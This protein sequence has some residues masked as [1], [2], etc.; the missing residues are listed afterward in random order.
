MT[1]STPPPV[2]ASVLHEGRRVPIGPAGLTIG[3]DE[4]ND[5]VLAVGRV[6]RHHARI[7]ADAGELWVEDLGSTNGTLL[8]GERFSDTARR[9]ENGDSVTI[10]ET[11]LRLL[12]GEE[13]RMASREQPV[14]ATRSVALTE[15]RLR[16]GRDDSNDLVLADP[17]VS[18]FHAEI[19]RSD[20]GVEL[21]D[22][23]SRNGTRVDGEAHDRAVLRPG[24]TIGIGPF[25]LV[26]DGSGLETR[27]D[28]GALRLEAR[29][30][31][32][33]AGGKRILQSTSLTLEPG[34]LTAVIGASG[35]GKSTLVKVL[36]GVSPPSEGTVTANGEPIESR[37]TDVAYVPQDEIV[38]G[39]LTVDEALGY[40][41]RLRLPGD[42]TAAEIA[43]AVATVEEEL[44]LEEQGGTRIASLSGG[45]RKRAGVA[46]ELISRAS[47]LFLDEPASGLDPGLES[48]MM[49]LL[50]ELADNSRSVTVVTHAT[51]NL[52]MCDRLVVLGEGGEATFV[53]R[54]REA[55]EFFEVETYDDIYTALVDRP[56]EEWRRRYESHDGQASEPP[57]EPVPELSEPRRPRSRRGGPYL[58]ALVGRYARLFLRDR[59]NLLALLGQVPLLALAVAFLFQPG[60]FDDKGGEPIRAAQL[61]FLLATATIWLGSIDAAREIVR[62]RALFARESAIGVPLHAYLLSKLVVLFVLIA[63]QTVVLA[64]IAFAVRP[65]GESVGTYAAVLGVLLVTGFV[66]V[67]VGLLVSAAVR[68]E[69]QAVSLVPL[70]IIPQLLFAGAIVPVEKM[71]APVAALSSVIFERWSFAGAGTAADMQDRLGADPEVLEVSGYGTGF[72]DVE[73]VTAYP[74]L[75]A[76]LAASLAGVVLLIRKRTG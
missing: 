19:V 73:A 2:L 23:G 72:F 75:A 17:N 9:L 15:D 39:L 25:R 67:G 49:A 76:F 6:S 48:R 7:Y 61:L 57:T 11:T 30:V 13:T 56:A 66:A 59:G 65:L 41:A 60:L 18:R 62:E 34:D 3:R 58:R 32:V 71:G 44:G 10:G 54:P 33:A 12:A 28:R 53:G 8:N 52:D 36:A 38:H 55:L 70:T 68:T 47:L 46:A 5:I 74:V 37:L 21:V 26:F 22:L 27:D 4:D 1:P 29:T 14:L 63:V 16:I 20:E 64:A 40:A 43:E 35:S 31:A 69:D 51:K 50:R 24:Q 42:S 45:Q